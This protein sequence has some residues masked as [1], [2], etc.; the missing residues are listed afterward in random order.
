MKELRPLASLVE[1]SK[2]RAPGYLEVC[3]ALGKRE[4]VDDNPDHDLL[5]FTPEDWVKIHAQYRIKI[6][7][8]DCLR[9]DP[10]CPRKS[11]FSPLQH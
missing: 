9:G 5:R 8:P 1:T 7:F 11:Q 10:D 3:L 6:R 2:R 4:K